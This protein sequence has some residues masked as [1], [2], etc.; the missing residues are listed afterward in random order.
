MATSG[1][2]NF[3]PAAADLMLNAWGRIG[4]RRSALTTQHL[5]DA[6]LEANL[7]QVQF[8]NRQPLWWTSELITQVLTAEDGEYDLATRVISIVAAYISTTSGSD[9]TDRIISQISTYDYAAIAN[10]LTPTG[11]PTVFKFERLTT[12]K[13][14]LWQVPDDTTTY[15]LKLQCLCQPEDVS[16]PSGVTVDAPYR[17]LDAFTAELAYRLARLY[18]PEME[19]ARKMDAR[20]AWDMAANQDVENVPLY[21]VPAIEGYFN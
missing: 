9:T 20:E 10:K 3:G 1:V 8:S 18:R 4:I 12:P 13:I 15:T 11:L 7:A 19:Q 6:A 17:F 16:L 14:T 2:W 5:L 21:V